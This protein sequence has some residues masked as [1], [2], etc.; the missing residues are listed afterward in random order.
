MSLVHVI[1]VS[2]ATNEVSAVDLA[3][4]LDVSKRNN[5]KIGITGMLLYRQGRFMQV[6]EGE[7]QLVDNVM[8]RI[9]ADARHTSVT[10]L[11]RHVILTR[12]F[13]N[14]S[15]GFRNI[16]DADMCA[17]PGFIDFFSQSFDSYKAGVKFGPPLIML[18]AFA[19]NLRL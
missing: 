7:S 15:M 2:T 10:I 5:Q 12:D 17:H 19:Q 16:S 8:A 9:K 14:W 4:L 6:L 3:E 13:A 1:Y 11:E 18:K